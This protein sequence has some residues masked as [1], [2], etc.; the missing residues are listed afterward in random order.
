MRCPIYDWSRNPMPPAWI[1]GAENALNN[2]TRLQ[3]PGDVLLPDFL[4]LGPVMRA[5]TFDHFG[6]RKRVP[7][8]LQ[9]EGTMEQGVHNNVHNW[10]GGEMASFDGAGNDPFFQLHHGQIDRIWEIWLGL[11]EGRSNPTD[12]DWLDHPFW[13]YGLSGLPEEIRVRDLLSTDA[14]GYTFEDLDW[15]HTLTP[16]ITPQLDPLLAELGESARLATLTLSEDT[17]AEIAALRRG[18]GPGRVSLT[19]ERLSLP[20]H[21]YEHRLFFVDADTKVSTYIGTFTILPIPDLVQGLERRVSSQVEVPPAVLD[22]ILAKS[23]NIHVIGVGVPLKGRKIPT[24]PVPFEGVT[25]TV[26]A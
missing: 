22:A 15:Q 2:P 9:V 23:D 26:D 14:L 3:A 10:M 20:L 4:E 25:L 19:Y 7:G 8:D 16:E 1:W 21:P 11:G 17:R 12:P 13:F 24:Q 18:N 6:G 5:R